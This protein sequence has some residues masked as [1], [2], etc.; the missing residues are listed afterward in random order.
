MVVIADIMD[1]ELGLTAQAIGTKDTL[2]A[3]PADVSKRVQI[4]ALIAATVKAFGRLD[5]MVNNAGIAK[6]QPFLEITEAD[7]DSVLDVNLKGAFFGVQA[8]GKQMI[9]QG[10]PGVIINMSSINALLANPSVATYAIS[11]GGMNQLTTIAAVAATAAGAST[12]AAA[13][14]ASSA[15]AACMRARTGGSCAGGAPAVSSGGRPSASARPASAASRSRR[16]VAV[17]LAAPS[18]AAAADDSQGDTV[19]AKFSHC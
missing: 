15:E 4:D 1:D 2:L 9:A 13:R 12:A 10:T 16:R 14:L 19:E 18:E 6:N 17:T 8:A 5:I 11:K 3:V 7:Y